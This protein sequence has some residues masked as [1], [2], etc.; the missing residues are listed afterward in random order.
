MEIRSRRPLLT[1]AIFAA[2][3]TC[4]VDLRARE[5]QPQKEVGSVSQDAFEEGATVEADD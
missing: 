4:M 5:P 1:L 3:S 2:I